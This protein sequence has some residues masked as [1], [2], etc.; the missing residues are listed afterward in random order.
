MKR[1]TNYL[2]IGAGLLALSTVVGLVTSRPVIAQLIKAALVRDV[3]SPLR[4]VWTFTGNMR[5][6]CNTYTVPT[7][8]TLVIEQIS[9]FCTL[10]IVIDSGL[11]DIG[12]FTF[13]AQLDSWATQMTRIYVKSGQTI[14]LAE[15][16]N[17]FG[18]ATL[19]GHMIDD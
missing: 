3:D 2:L 11:P 5:S 15:L 4:Q 12:F 7:N 9:C 18:D 1:I 10:Q 13:P 17:T 8:K 19:H 14:T 16:G 6:C